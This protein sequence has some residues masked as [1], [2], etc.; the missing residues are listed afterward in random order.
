MGMISLKNRYNPIQIR[1]AISHE[2]IAN[3]D[4]TRQMWEQTTWQAQAQSDWEREQERQFHFT[5]QQRYWQ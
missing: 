5:A 2:S 4:A 1:Q 3:V